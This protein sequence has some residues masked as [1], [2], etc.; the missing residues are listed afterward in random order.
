MMSAYVDWHNGKTIVIEGQLQEKSLAALPNPEQKSQSLPH[1]MAPSS[2]LALAFA[3]IA[4]AAPK[5]Q[6][7]TPLDFVIS[8]FDTSLT[9]DTAVSPAKAVFGTGCV[10][11]TLPQGGSALVRISTSSPHGYVTGWSEA[12]C[13]G[14][15]VVVFTTTDGCTSFE[16][17]SVK[18]W[19]GAAPFDESGK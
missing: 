4:A 15:A 17:A 16:D 11:R 1:E 9:C 7:D 2:I 14:T 10:N 12:D 13:K 6:A 3:T 18:S 19:I 5:P 8:V